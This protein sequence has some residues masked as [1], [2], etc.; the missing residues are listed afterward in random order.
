MVLHVYCICD[1]HS[2]VHSAFLGISPFVCTLRQISPPLALIILVYE[3][4]R[5]IHLDNAQ[6][7]NKF[8]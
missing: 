7:G 8:L 6:I 4:I 5:I 1:V 2:A 3:L